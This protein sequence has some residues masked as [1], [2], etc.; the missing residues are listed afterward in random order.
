MNANP[1]STPL[2][3][4]PANALV[5]DLKSL[6]VIVNDLRQPTFASVVDAGISPA[7]RSARNASER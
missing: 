2:E 7:G 4:D 3:D 5:S 6:E 1:D